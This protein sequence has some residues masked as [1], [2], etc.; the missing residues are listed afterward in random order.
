V[1]I[2]RYFKPSGGLEP[3]TPS[4]TMRCLRQPVATSGNG[5]ALF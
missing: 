1:A 2:Y 4:V 5:F 3:P